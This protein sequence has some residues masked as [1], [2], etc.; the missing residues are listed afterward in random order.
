MI[1]IQEELERNALDTFEEIAAKFDVPLSWV[2]VAHEILCEQ[3]V[4][5]VE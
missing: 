4:L 3:K 5:G 2:Y 1:S